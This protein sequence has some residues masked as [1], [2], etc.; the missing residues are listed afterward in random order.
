MRPTKWLPIALVFGVA[1][2]LCAATVELH[3]IDEL[4]QP[5]GSTDVVLQKIDATS[6]RRAYRMRRVTDP[7]GRI[8]F[9]VAEPGRYSVRVFGER[10]RFVELRDHP[11]LPRQ[12]ITIA[13][14]GDQIRSTLRVVRGTPVVFR[15]SVAGAELP[16]ARVQLHDLDREYRTE[17]GMRKLVEREVR[18]VAG[19]WTARVDP[20][21][22][23]LLT[24]V[25]VNRT[26]FPND[27]AE[28]D[29]PLGTQA[30]YVNF[31]FAAQAHI[32][33]KV[34]FED[35]PFGVRIVS[36]LQEAGAWLPAV[37]ARGGSKVD[38]VEARPIYPNWEYEMIVPEGRFVVRPEADGLER[39]DP[40]E[41]ELTLRPGD[42]ERIDFVVAGNN[43]GGGKW[44]RV[45]VDD[46]E[47]KPAPNAV[48][49][50]WPADP[51]ARRDQPVAEGR[52]G[53]RD[54]TLRGLSDTEYLFVAGK[55]GFVEAETIRKPPEE[56]RVRLQLGRGATLH[57]VANDPDEEP[58]PGVEVVL[59]REDEYV[60]LLADREIAAWAARPNAVTDGTGHLWMRGVYPGSY[61]LS[62]TFEGSDAEMFFAEF[63][64]KG[65]TSWE[66]EMEKE[67]RGAEEDEIEIRLAPA[68]VL[69]ASLHCSDGSE[70]PPEADILVLDGLRT[71]DPDR[72]GEDA[73]HKADA[74]VLEGER[75]DG[76]H[77][78]P[79]DPGAYH[80]LVRPQ[81]HNR[82][83]WAL[84][85][86]SQ[87]DAA[88]LNVGPGEPTDLG[89]V[90]ID[91]A[92]AISVRP[93]PPD[94]VELPDLL[95]TGRYDP[96]A[97]LDGI[98]KIEGKQRELGS[99]GLLADP[100]R[101]QFRDLPEGEVEATV[102]V[103]NPLFLPSPE[104]SVAING[105]L[106]R[107][108]TFEVAPRLQGIGG[109]IEID[110]TRL[111]HPETPIRAVRVESVADP[112]D[113]KPAAPRIIEVNDARIL[114][115]SLPSGAYDLD[116]CLDTE[117]ADRLPLWRELDIIAGVIL[118]GSGPTFQHS[119][120]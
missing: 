83:T 17:V 8:L 85:T 92:P 111:Q 24:S 86:E 117:C 108:R 53:W 31:E 97:E 119:G 95:A 62:G 112:S 84:G 11:E 99:H 114:I 40:P 93:I 9:Q 16:G 104:L 77:L 91:C 101:V 74:Y 23:Y 63:R 18:L 105:T 51:D 21:P 57:A 1:S 56:G 42:Y 113:D 61:R 50:A 58:A 96:L 90:A 72:R 52:T 65:D 4:D 71:P 27:V 2:S 13:D 100:M 12:S 26:V 10:G 98:V 43:R 33:G 60:S 103:W 19:R 48:V 22:G 15:V 45:R 25:E 102:T 37:Q 34:T 47:N 87:E 79:L 38:R 30:W 115:P 70:L 39:A 116:L 41:V 120:K 64:N 94:G 109:A 107:G 73:V 88:V 76:F 59:T 69:Q 82:W 35:E 36:H 67:Y 75:R 78:G 32:W 110:L 118:T 29:L 5:V 49:E 80:L 55:P 20:V 54:A 6:G 28:F 14:A 106:E 7:R 81:D 46:P 68:G 3:V 89:G 44:T 66:R